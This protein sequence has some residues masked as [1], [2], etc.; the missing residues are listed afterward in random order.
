M[1]YEPKKR[2][3]FMRKTFTYVIKNLIQ[4]AKKQRN[5]FKIQIN[6]PLNSVD[7]INSFELLLNN[8]NLNKVILLTDEMQEDFNDNIIDALIEKLLLDQ[9]FSL[10]IYVGILENNLENLILKRLLLNRDKYSGK[11]SIIELGIK[12][13]VQGVFTNTGSICL[14]FRTGKR[15]RRSYYFKIGR[16]H[17]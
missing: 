7:F 5:G 16:A 9:E 17:V 12:P 4:C 2:I 11:I 1:D 8:K 10:T 14:D 3:G 6:E 13:L 15:K